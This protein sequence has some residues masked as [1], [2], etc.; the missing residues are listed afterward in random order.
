MKKKKFKKKPLNPTNA[1]NLEKNKNLVG[2]KYST[3]VN[4]M[5]VITSLV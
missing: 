5:L 2:A 3:L 1:Q 4:A